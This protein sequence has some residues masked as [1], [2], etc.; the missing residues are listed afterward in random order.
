MTE[1]TRSV[2]L[3]QA[4]FLIRTRGYAAF[5]YADLA[6]T[7]GIT[8]ASVHYHFPTKEDL[9][10]VLVQQY[11]ERFIATLAAIR[12]RHAEPAPRLREYALLFLDGF[13]QGMLPL[14]G[15]LSAERMALPASMHGTIHEFF[16]L[17][18]E[19]L[20]GVLEEGLATG[21][22]ARRHAAGPRGAAPAQHPRGRHLRRLGLAGKRHR[23]GRVR[24]G[25]ARSRA[26]TPSARKRRV[27]A[28]SGLQRD[29][30]AA[31][32][33]PAWIHQGLRK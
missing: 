10:T 21:A 14:C 32:C 23:A 2:I 29:V 6:Q 12:Q 13:E 24:G 20:E 30:P 22:R 19:W 33:R 8:K 28:A 7:A 5:S 4:E 11:L 3:R 31:W 18:L 16:R 17:H 9:V 26:L 1:D 15:A 25:D 27:L